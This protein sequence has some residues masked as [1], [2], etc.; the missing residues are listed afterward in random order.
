MRAVVRALALAL[1]DPYLVHSRRARLDIRE[2]AGSAQRHDGQGG[3]LF[4]SACWQ[5]L[6]GSLMFDFDS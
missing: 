1:S 3:A 2:Q 6:F 5:S 4:Q